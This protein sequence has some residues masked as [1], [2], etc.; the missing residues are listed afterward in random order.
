MCA[1]CPFSRG[2]RYIGI[3]RAKHA[4]MV[5]DWSINI[6]GVQENALVKYR[7]DRIPSVLTPPDKFATALN[8]L[9]LS[10]I[11]SAAA[12]DVEDEHWDDGIIGVDVL[13]MLKEG[14]ARPTDACVSPEIA[15]ADFEP[16]PLL[17][18][19]LGVWRSHAEVAALW[20]W[21]SPTLSLGWVSFAR[22]DHL[23]RRKQKWPAP[24]GM[25]RDIT[26]ESLGGDD[27]LQILGGDTSGLSD[28]KLDDLWKLTLAEEE[29]AEKEN[30]LMECNDE[31]SMIAVV[32]APQFQRIWYVFR[33][34]PLHWFSST[35]MLAIAMRKR[36]DMG[37]AATER[38]AA[39]SLRKA[40]LRE[41]AHVLALSRCYQAD[42]P[43]LD[44]VHPGQTAPVNE[45]RSL[46]LTCMIRAGT[47]SEKRCAAMFLGA[48][49]IDEGRLSAHPFYTKFFETFGERATSADNVLIKL[50]RRGMEQV[51]L[52]FNKKVTLMFP[53][54]TRDYTA[55]ANSISVCSQMRDPNGQ[56]VTAVEYYEAFTELFKAHTSPE[57][58]R[59]KSTK[60]VREPQGPASGAYFG[61][62]W[63]D[64]SAGE[65]DTDSSSDNA[66]ILERTDPRVRFEKPPHVSGHCMAP[67]LCDRMIA[68]IGTCEPRDKSPDA[69]AR[70]VAILPEH[71]AESLAAEFTKWQSG[72]K[73][74]LSPE[75][76]RNMRVEFAEDLCNF[77]FAEAYKHKL[78]NEVQ[79]FHNKI[80][81]ERAAKTAKQVLSSLPE[82]TSL[83][84]A[85]AEQETRT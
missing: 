39:E 13:G 77:L 81:E 42:R 70:V 53:T 20:T 50:G 41:F 54:W 5:F 49:R 84:D 60:R 22:L 64:G 31:L 43:A 57:V 44:N 24:P 34:Y 3:E 59:P 55:I 40:F 17:W 51:N 71:I 63:S 68:M 21:T 80:A 83:P 26:Y 52:D 37:I 62:S 61:R 25:H 48:T 7:K 30:E 73:F 2:A 75:H 67:S 78:A 36:L 69:M 19:S 1:I 72:M 58:W 16:N 35:D 47:I 29:R 14:R 76:V 74:Q 38:D 66:E 32:N 46:Q 15:K 10:T 12:A 28:K 85:K 82:S 23:L 6:F 79:E 4:Y 8:A 33:R 11:A 9:E 45:Q 18:Q 56:H 27:R 65:A